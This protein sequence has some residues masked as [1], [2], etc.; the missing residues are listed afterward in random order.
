MAYARGMP[1]HAEW[2]SNDDDFNHFFG[3]TVVITAKKKPNFDSGS[4]AWTHNE[5]HRWFTLPNVSGYSAVGL[6]D[7]HDG[8]FVGNNGQILKISF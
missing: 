5:G 7:P 4:A 1:P 3:R 8:W 6:A 2:W